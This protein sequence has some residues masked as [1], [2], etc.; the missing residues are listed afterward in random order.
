MLPSEYM[1]MS[2]TLEGSKDQ[3][4]NQSRVNNKIAASFGFVFLSLILKLFKQAY[5]AYKSR[6]NINTILTMC[7]HRWTQRK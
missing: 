1:N 4:Q 7:V 2:I 3:N 6:L 5:M